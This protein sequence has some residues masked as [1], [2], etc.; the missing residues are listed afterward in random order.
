MKKKNGQ[1]DRENE[2][3]CAYQAVKYVVQCPYEWLD[4]TQD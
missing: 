3:T 2:I 1:L 4:Y